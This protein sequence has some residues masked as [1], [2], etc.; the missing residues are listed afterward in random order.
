MFAIR[1]T[2]TAKVNTLSLSFHLKIPSRVSTRS[3]LGTTYHG[4]PLLSR[5][6]CPRYLQEA[7]A[8]IAGCTERDVPTEAL[9]VVKDDPD[10]YRIVECAVASGS[11][12]IATDSDLLRLGEYAGIQVI[13]GNDFLQRGSSNPST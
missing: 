1:H 3:Q 5:R 13:R 12:C 6:G 2:P 9:D 10:D 4:S 11:Y 8:I 7:Q